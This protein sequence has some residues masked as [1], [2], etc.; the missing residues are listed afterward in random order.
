MIFYYFQAD[1]FETNNINFLFGLSMPSVIGYVS[2][3]N[4]KDAYDNAQNALM[5]KT[6]GF[7]GFII[8][9]IPKEKV[10]EFRT[11]INEN[12]IEHAK[13]MIKSF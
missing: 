10:N 7:A 2:A 4:K 12:K 3:P 8:K 11:V 9:R 5:K 6:G 13:K 1:V